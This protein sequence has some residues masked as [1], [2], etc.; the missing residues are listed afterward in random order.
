MRFL[1]LVPVIL[2]TC[3]WTG[4]AVWTGWPRLA[5]VRLGDGAESVTTV[6]VAGRPALLIANRNQARLEVVRFDAATTSAK[7]DPAAVNRLP[8][9]PG[10]AVE[11]IALPAPPVDALALGEVVVAV[12]GPPWRVTAWRR[13][14]AG[15]DA[16][17]TQELLDGE[18]ERR[19]G[20]LLLPGSPP[21]L[22]IGCGNGIQAVPLAADGKPGRPEWIKPRSRGRGLAWGLTDLDGDGDQDLVEAFAAT[23]GGSGVRWQE[24][25]GGALAPA[26]SIHDEPVRALAVLGG[27]HPLALL[28]RHQ[29]DSVA[30]CALENAPSETLGRTL[31][32]PLPAQ[33]VVSGMRVGGKAALAVAMPGEAR[34]ELQLLT[35]R[36]WRDGGSF[37]A[38]K[39]VKGLAAPAPDLLLLWSADQGELLASRW[40]DG[41][42]G[43]P[44]PW[45]P[46]GA[47]PG[48]ER[49]IV[50]LDGNELADW[51]F[52]RDGE[53]L[54]LWVWKTGAAAAEP[55]RFVKAGAKISQ[56]QWLGGTRAV[57][58]SGF[59][60]DAELLVAAGTDACQRI[61]AARSP[62]LARLEPARLRLVAWDG[63]HRPAR[64]ADGA[65]QWLDADLVPTDQVQLAPVDDGELLEVR[66]V[67]GTAWALAAK[68]RGLWR[69]E[70]GP[71]GLLRPAQRRALGNAD[72]LIVDRWLGLLALGGEG[73]WL[74]QDGAAPRLVRRTKADLTALP[75]PQPPAA[76]RLAATALLGRGSD[77]LVH[78]DGA[79]RLLLFSGT[80][81]P[82]AAWPVWEDRGPP[83]GGDDEGR[84]AAA[85]EPHAVCGADLDGDGRNDLALLCHDR[86]LL[87]LTTPEAR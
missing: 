66:Q 61:A 16:L 19:L 31:A 57:V 55:T 76:T 44:Q 27:A 28:G 70:A 47:A 81:T 37:P 18:P 52:Q 80:G 62:A 9:P 20:T 48:G 74:L 58:R 82:V 49:A 12:H 83:Y 71:G 84:K 30:L 35:V 17:A 65:W 69:L 59:N 22:L 14:A 77:L 10:I 4:E 34:I 29:R 23:A 86:L 15:W 8:L 43:F 6:P 33:A 11:R 25:D 5:V 3:G 72:R 13:G 73:A 7:P 87:Y 54:V 24:N 36:G 79:R 53:D 60:G 45:R 38:P 50:G 67:A 78:D 40:Q 2:A 75:S 85:A 56:A 1:C 63:A 39:A 64:L 26:Q 41:R 46:D 51:W 21:R 68:G 32:V 42:L